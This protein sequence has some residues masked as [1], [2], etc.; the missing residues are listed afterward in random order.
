M[1]SKVFRLCYLSCESKCPPLFCEVNIVLGREGDKG[2]LRTSSL[3]ARAKFLGC[4][5]F[6]VVFASP[7]SAY[8]TTSGPGPLCFGPLGDPGRAQPFR[9]KLGAWAGRAEFRHFCL[10]SDARPL[11]WEALLLTPGSHPEAAVGGQADGTGAGW[12]LTTCGNRHC[13]GGV[14]GSGNFSGIM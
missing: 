14:L 13:L 4:V 9:A 12:G 3:E 2:H 5:C 8:S 1:I 6:C 7:Q 10:G 11:S